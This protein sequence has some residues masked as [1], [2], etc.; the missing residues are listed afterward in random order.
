MDGDGE[1]VQAMETEHIYSCFKHGL[2]IKKLLDKEIFK[3]D[4]QVGPKI[5]PPSSH[6]SGEVRWEGKQ[7]IFWNAPCLTAFLVFDSNSS[8]LPLDHA[9]QR[10]GLQSFDV[11]K[12]CDTKWSS[13]GFEEYRKNLCFN[14]PRLHWQRRWIKCLKLS[15]PI[16]AVQSD[17]DCVKVLLN[18]KAGIEGQGD[19][20]FS[21][22]K[23]FLCHLRSNTGLVHPCLSLPLLNGKLDILSYLLEQGAKKNLKDIQNSRQNRS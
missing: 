3:I 18:Y 7:E 12:C 10:R 21:M 9:E 1:P 2:K 14:C 4:R 17:L 16:I 8:C 15:P 6:D 19:L 22:K 23:A 11:W 20:N 5:L 13:S